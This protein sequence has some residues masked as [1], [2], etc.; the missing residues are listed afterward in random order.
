MHSACTCGG[1][2]HAP[3][4][5]RARTYCANKAQWPQGCEGGP[6]SWYVCWLDSHELHQKMRCFR[7]NAHYFRDQLRISVR[8]GG[9][10]LQDDTQLNKSHL[11]TPSPRQPTHSSLHQS[12]AGHA[13]GEQLVHSN[14]VT[15]PLIRRPPCHAVRGR[16]LTLRQSCRD[17]TLLPLTW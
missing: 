8:S 9:K 17:A 11:T 5:A 10:C 1:V 12:G 4:R 16:L 6:E 7:V 14:L 13:L 15:A 2:H 3:E